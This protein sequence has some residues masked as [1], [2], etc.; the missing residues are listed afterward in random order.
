[1][2]SNAGEKK[3]SIESKAIPTNL[4]PQQRSKETEYPIGTNILL[5][6]N[7][8]ISQADDHQTYPAMAYSYSSNYLIVWD[9]ERFYQSLGYYCVYGQIVDSQGGMV[10]EDFPISIVMSSWGKGSPAVAYNS[11]NGDFLV[12]FQ[13]FNDI[14]GQLVSTTGS[15]IGTPFAISIA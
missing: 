7:F 1:M 5:K 14:F 8:V 11:Y 3:G 13:L 12:V 10:G 2:K 4:Y 9:D 6:K 15:L